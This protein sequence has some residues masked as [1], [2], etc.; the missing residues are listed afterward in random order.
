MGCRGSCN[1]SEQ[2]ENYKKK[3]KSLGCHFTLEANNI[4]QW[5]VV[6]KMPVWSEKA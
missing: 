6:G 2:L 5:N 3:Y 1:K 4:L